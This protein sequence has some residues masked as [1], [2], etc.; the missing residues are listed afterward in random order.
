MSLAELPAHMTTEPTGRRIRGV[1]IGVSV[2]E[3]LQREGTLGVTA[4]ANELGHSKSTVHSHLRTL[5]DEGLVVAEDGGY[6][7]SLK[8]LSIARDVRDHVADYDVIENEVDELAS[9]TGEIV[10]FG[11]EE[12]ERVSY[13]YKAAGDRAVTTASRIGTQQPIHST[14]LGKTIL[15]HLPADRREGIVDAL[16]LDGRTETTITDRQALREELDRIVDR[17][18]GIDDEENIQGLRCVAAPVL[19]DDEVLGA[20]SISGPSSRITDERLHGDLADSVRRAAN[21]IELNTK[22]G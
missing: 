9:E 4:I 1:Q 8:F 22:F 2:I 21:V 14:A 13:L 15:A 11:I 5:A 20:I 17:G 10:Q 3:L 12:Y 6:R 16:D 18:Y 7:L 19:D